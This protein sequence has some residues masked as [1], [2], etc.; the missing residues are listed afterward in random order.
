MS[1]W[2]LSRATSSGREFAGTEGLT[3]RTGGGGELDDRREIGIQ[4]EAHVWQQSRSGRSRQGDREDGISVRRLL[5]NLGSSN[6]LD[7]SGLVLDEDAPSLALR[8]FVCNDAT[9]DVRRRA[10]CG[11][12]GNPDH[13]GWIRLRARRTRSRDN[14]CQQRQPERSGTESELLHHF[15][16]PWTAPMALGYAPSASCGRR[17]VFGIGKA[18]KKWGDFRYAETYIPDVGLTCRH[19]VTAGRPRPRLVI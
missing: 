6:R 14:E 3:T 4:R 10:S 9:H 18:T 15:T 13:A 1:G 19:P 8:K 11:R 7:C 16:P 17:C 12:A 2:R 5:E